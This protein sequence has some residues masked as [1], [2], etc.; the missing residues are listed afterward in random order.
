MDQARPFADAVAVRDGRIVVVG[1]A[2]EALALGGDGTQIVDLTDRSLIPGMIDNH[3]HMAN[4]WQRV[5]VDVTYPGCRT[6]NDVVDAMAAAAE[7]RPPG[8]WVI[9]RGYEPGRLTERR[10]P[11]RHD[12]DR[13]IPDHKVGLCNREGMGWTFN[14]AG[15]RAIGVDDETPDPPG[16]PLQRDASGI[17]LGP[18]WDNAR[19]AFVVPNIPRPSDDEV[20]DGY[21]WIQRQLLSFGVT[22]AHEAGYKE[23]RHARAWITL[24]R[25][26]GVGIRV[27]LGPYGLIGS[28]WDDGGAP[29]SLVLTGL[30]TGF[31]DPSL[32]L[33]SIQMGVDG[34]IIG[35]TAALF[36]P[37]SHRS[38]GY[39]GSFRVDQATLSSAVR[40][41]DEAGWS[42][43]L[44]CQGE[45]GI[46]RALTAIRELGG[47]QVRHRL[48]HAYQWT[49]PLMDQ[50]AR[51]GVAWNTQPALLPL[52]GP[53]LRRWFGER[54]RWAFPFRSM[55]ER[56]VVVS[57]GSDWG[58]GPLDP[59]V[60]IDALV[61]H[62]SDVLPGADTFE[63]AERISLLDALAIYTRGGAIAGSQEHDRGTIS[64]G[65][66][67]DL[68][69][70]SRDI[71]TLRDDDVPRLRVTRT[72]VGGSVRYEAASE[73]S[74]SRISVSEVAARGHRAACH[75]AG[76]TVDLRKAWRTD[77]GIGGRWK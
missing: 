34:G 72:Y 35:A 29:G 14:T 27:V 59:F 75:H 63:P 55:L 76:H 43:G 58:V 1:S 36:E 12:L 26:H 61:N 65:K 30:A 67:A 6:V 21:D 7:G 51:L 41:A 11:D 77:P 53:Y 3:V 13:G 16:G 2:T 40:R 23:A 54:A 25:K 18:M 49:P 8:S 42:T 38:D 24:Q 19:T 5:W 62:R 17:P 33:G 4:A 44:I 39:C 56:G 66:L 73:R 31:G 50:M 15:L 28:S 57:A 47:S 52:T 71:R 10:D 37:Y 74:R 22:T 32:S 9:G 69:V 20:V 68:A 70:L 48:E 60:G 64:V 46:D 45:A